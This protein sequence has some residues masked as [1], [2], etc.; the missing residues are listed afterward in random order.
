MKSVLRF[1]AIFV[2]VAIL[3]SSCDKDTDTPPR[4]P[5]VANAGNSQ[6]IQLPANTATL[7]GSGITE[8][9]K[10]TGYQWGLVS[11]PNVPVI[12]SENSATTTAKGL[13]AGDYIFQLMVI[14]SVGLTDVDTVSWVVIP[15]PQQTLTLQPANNPNE[16]H[17]DSYTNTAG[18]SDTEIP[19]GAWTVLGNPINWRELL[20]FDISQIPANA[21]IL[22]AN[23]YLYAMPNPHGGDMINAHSGTANACYIERVVANWTFTGMNWANQPATTAANRVVITQSTSA[24]QDNTID[25]KALLEDILTNGNYGFEIRMQNE[26]IYNVRQ[27]ASSYHS[28]AALHPKL[29]ITYQ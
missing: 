24:F 20:S 9:F 19:V 5:P 11:G 29:V 26:T 2:T 16:G 21:T 14:D 4:N 25:V 28:N 10:I 13:I 22:S 12:T 3:F 7:T 17:V 8:N 15:A 27:Y 23:L 1:S 18:T 6:T